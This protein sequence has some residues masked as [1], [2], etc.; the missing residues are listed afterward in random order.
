MPE[1]PEVETIAVDLRDAHLVG[2]KIERACVYWER[3]VVHDTPATFCQ[4]IQSQTIRK[5]SRRGKYIVFTLDKET[6]FVHL[7]MTGKFHIEEEDLPP[8]SHERIRLYLSDKRILRYEDQR[9]FGKWTLT[10]DP[11][12]FMQHI[13]IEPLSDDFT[14]QSFQKLLE[15]KNRQIKP[16]Y[17]IRI[18]WRV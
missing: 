16:F 15:G 2:L 6:L 17:S 9:K 5:I 4:R 13:G 14:L 3:S 10:S 8:S 11:D 18:F 1:L 12:V 7:R